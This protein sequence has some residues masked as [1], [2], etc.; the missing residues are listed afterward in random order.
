[1][2]VNIETVDLNAPVPDHVRPESVVDFDLYGDR[3][4]VETGDMHAGLWK[5]GQEKGW[6]IFWTPH[7]GGHWLINDYELLFD[8][9]RQPELFSNQKMTLPPMP[10]EPLLLPLGLDPPVHGA[11]R[12]PLMKAFAPNV[13]RAMERD[14]RNFAAELIDGIAR[15][16]RCEFVRAI[17]VPMPVM[18]FMK[19]MGMPLDRLDEFR[20]WVLDMSSNDNERRAD[21][22][23]KCHALM[24]ELIGERQ[25]ERGDD[26]ISQLI[27]ADV[28]GRPPTFDELQAYCMLLFAAGLDTVANSLAFGVNYL[29]GDA[30]LQ[31]ELRASPETIPV[32]VE[33]FLRRF[34][35]T[36]PPRT[37]TRDFNFGGVDI[38]KG[39]RVVM[40]TPAANLDPKIFPDPMR[41]DLDREN[42]VHVTFHSGPH[43]CVGSHLARL[44]LRV[45]YGEWF[46]RMPNI[47]HDPDDPVVLHM[48]IAMGLARLP[49][50]WDA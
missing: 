41:F 22:Y 27:D 48:S 25:A 26:L 29:A 1:L 17:G 10:E 40:M 39:E 11:F 3:R 50:I 7:N 24:A 42:K 20:E 38:K 49:I 6:G 46:K 23:V 35:I 2:V 16:G 5:L 4:W 18:I 44:E 13:I 12:L 34:G 37:A 30:R 36:N 43:R 14:I 21:S 32:A 33:E 8:A 9:V 45:F 15:D 47:R 31:N 28:G 19:L